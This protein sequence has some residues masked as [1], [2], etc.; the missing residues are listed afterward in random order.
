MFYYWFDFSFR[1]LKQPEV[2][3]VTL[4]SIDRDLIPVSTADNKAVRPNL[5]RASSVLIE[6]LLI[7]LFLQEFYK[8]VSLF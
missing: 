6:I 4:H 7:H 5:E 8:I 2:S 1:V 3:M